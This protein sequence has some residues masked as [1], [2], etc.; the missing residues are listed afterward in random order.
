[1]D[2]GAEVWR[3]PLLATLSSAACR[4]ELP[5]PD[6]GRFLGSSG[7]PLLAAC[8]MRAKASC[9]E[10]GL[11]Y[12]PMC[13]SDTDTAEKQPGHLQTAAGCA[14]SQRQLSFQICLQGVQ[15]MPQK[16]SC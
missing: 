6:L 9:I 12:R 5:G 10:E 4:R 1:M 3:V 8:C 16:G 2:T 11:S 13:C 7:C 15:A 14:F